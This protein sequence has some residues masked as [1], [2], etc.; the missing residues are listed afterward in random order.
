[1]CCVRYRRSLTFCSRNISTTAVL[2]S[3]PRLIQSCPH[4]PSTAESRC[5]QR[6][7]R[8]RRSGSE[9]EVPPPAALC[10]ELSTQGGQVL[11]S[12]LMVWNS[13]EASLDFLQWLMR[14]LAHCQR[15]RGHTHTAGR[16]VLVELLD[17]SLSLVC[18]SCCSKIVTI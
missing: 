8:Q 1:M 10:I 12:S 15:R 16:P 13:E 14:V 4:P 11:V 7:W 6:K 2:C 9:V 3:V 5:R 18:C 17:L